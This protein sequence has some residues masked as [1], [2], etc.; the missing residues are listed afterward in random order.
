M[1]Y[2]LKKLVIVPPLLWRRFVAGLY[3]ASIDLQIGDLRSP[4]PSDVGS[5]G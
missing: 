4:E 3:H 5:Y 1:L 2:D